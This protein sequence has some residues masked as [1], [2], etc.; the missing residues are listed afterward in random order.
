MKTQ[1]YYSYL[2]LHVMIIPFPSIKQV[3]RRPGREEEKK[4]KWAQ[5]EDTMA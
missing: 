4:K 1:F 5:Q 2:L 3:V